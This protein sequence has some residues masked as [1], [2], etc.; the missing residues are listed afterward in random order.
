MNEHDLQ[1]HLCHLIALRFPLFQN[2]MQKLH[3]FTTHSE[4]LGL[5]TISCLLGVPSDSLK[6]IENMGVKKYTGQNSHAFKILIAS[7]DK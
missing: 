2:C 3:I 7:T 5:I 1:K 6:T 4:A